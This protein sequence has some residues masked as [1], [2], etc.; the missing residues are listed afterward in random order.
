MDTCTPPFIKAA[1]TWIDCK[2]FLMWSI[3]VDS[4]N[5]LESGGGGEGKKILFKQ[6][7]VLWE[8]GHIFHLGQPST[9]LSIF[10]GVL[11]FLYIQ[12]GKVHIY[13][14]TKHAK[15]RRL[16]L[17]PVPG[18]HLKILLTIQSSLL[19]NTTSS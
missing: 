18:T 11:I 19:E 17:I 7:S 15:R 13:F 10:R 8:H 14:H 16:C 1:C 6:I 5:I 3:R 9:F 2:H 12:I 4:S